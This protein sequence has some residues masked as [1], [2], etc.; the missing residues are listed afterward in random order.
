M[1]KD[2]DIL[3]TM[4]NSA[5]TK[6]CVKSNEAKNVF[7]SPCVKF[8][9]VSS[10][11]KSGK[12]YKYQNHNITSATATAYRRR[13]S[14]AKDSRTVNLNEEDE[15][16]GDDEDEDCGGEEEKINVNDI[17]EW[18]PRSVSSDSIVESTYCVDL[19]RRLPSPL[20]IKVKGRFCPDMN[21]VKKVIYIIARSTAVPL[22]HYVCVCVCV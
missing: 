22:V 11:S 21:Y 4:G 12:S 13:S 8:S 7:R 16:G 18:F 10:P 20:S 5:V 2:T 17:L 9:P 14:D 15:E 3:R 1:K 19:V 6:K